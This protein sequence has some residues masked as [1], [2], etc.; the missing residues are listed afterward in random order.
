MD[1]SY[2]TKVVIDGNEL[3]LLKIDIG[4]GG[5]PFGSGTTRSPGLATEEVRYRA[6]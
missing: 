5:L 1:K 6:I 3:R 2:W 4:I